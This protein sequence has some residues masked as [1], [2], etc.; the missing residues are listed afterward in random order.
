M[1]EQLIKTSPQLQTNDCYSAGEREWME[2]T[3]NWRAEWLSPFFR[4]LTNSGVT[5]DH[6]TCSSFLI[7]MTF[8]PLWL[9]VNPLAALTALA[10]HV[11]L[12]G[13]D[14]GLARYQGTASGRGSF[15]DSV[16]DQCVFT[17]VML[18][19]MLTGLIS[20]GAGTVL[21]FVYCLVVAFAMVR[22]ALGRPYSWLIRPRFYIYGWI[23]LELAYLQGTLELLCWLAVS[24][25]VYKAITGFRAICRHLS[26]SAE[27]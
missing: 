12:D 24:I 25:L 22:N 9:L 20:I 26:T 4:F 11:F 7:G 15:I 2:S 16:T 17:G 3:Q 23:V 14:G 19:M 10:A 21:I 5:A 18:T 13:I 6:I 8:L 1:P 27:L